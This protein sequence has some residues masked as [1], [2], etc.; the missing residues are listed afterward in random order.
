MLFIFPRLKAIQKG[1]LKAMYKQ[2]TMH[3]SSN[4]VV[5]SLHQQRTLLQTSY[6]CEV[7]C[8]R[9]FD[10]RSTWWQCQNVWLGHHWEIPSEDA[11]HCLEQKVCVASFTPFGSRR[12]NMKHRDKW[13]DEEEKHCFP[14]KGWFMFRVALFRSP[15]IVQVR[16]SALKTIENTFCNGPAVAARWSMWLLY[17][18][19]QYDQYIV[20]RVAVS[21]MVC[22]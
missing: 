10:I 3:Q 9:R 18:Q 22:F 1:S 15:T 12:A 11:G 5:C 19:S 8:N 20:S 4:N 13:K 7:A 6:D 2:L 21:N 16:V 14:P 17:G